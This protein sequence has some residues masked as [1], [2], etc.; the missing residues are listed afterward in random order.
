[1]LEKGLR[2]SID[3][4]FMGAAAL[5]VLAA[6]LRMIPHPPNFSPL[7]AMAL[8]GGAY[9][10]RKSWAVFLPVLILFA[11]DLIIGFH[12]YMLAV[13]SSIILISF[14][15]AGLGETPRARAVVGRSVLGS[16]MFFL[17]TNFAVW[18]QSGFFEM[19][20]SGLMKCYA[21]AL[22]FFQNT[23]AGDLFY[24]TLLFG[25]WALVRRFFPQPQ[26]A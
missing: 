3:A 21:V 16:T 25:G 5:V 19:N 4:Q 9:L 23:L 17:I 14:L 18:T 11:T 13:Y 7:S 15:G 26:T 10:A 2:R 1:M 24:S 6:F 22:P 12:S 20:L 8:F